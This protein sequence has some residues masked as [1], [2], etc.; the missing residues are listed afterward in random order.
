[1]LKTMKMTTG[2]GE[3]SEHYV[4]IITHFED[5]DLT[6]F[7]LF[8][9]A[10]ITRSAG[11]YNELI[12][13]ETGRVIGFTWPLDSVP[14]APIPV[15]PVEKIGDRALAIEALRRAHTYIETHVP[16]IEGTLPRDGD[17]LLDDVYA[18]QAALE[19][20]LPSPVEIV[21]MAERLEYVSW[22]WTVTRTIMGEA[23]ALLRKFL[24]K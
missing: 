15:Q 24:P 2:R 13:M 21:A 20:S 23:A 7:V 12:D 4:P 14:K 11:E 3:M 6:E 19:K 17:A 9:R 10:T 8:D 1:M 18:A 16:T 22:D 5:S